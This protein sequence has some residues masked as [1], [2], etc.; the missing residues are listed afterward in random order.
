[1]RVAMLR[2]AR[3]ASFGLQ[4]LRGQVNRSLPV[5]AS[6]FSTSAPLCDSGDSQPKVYE[7]RTYHI[8]PP[9]FW[10]FMEI[11]EEKIHLRMQLSKLVGFW[12][13]DFA[14]RTEVGKARSAHTGWMSTLNKLLP[15][16]ESQD[17]VLLLPLPWSQLKYPETTGGCYELRSYWMTPGSHLQEPFRRTIQA[18][19]AFRYA[20]LLGVWS[21]EFG[22]LNR[23]YMLWH[24]QDLDQ[25]M[26]G[27]ARAAQ[28]PTI[29]AA[30]RE[31]APNLVHQWSKILLPTSFSPM[32]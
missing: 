28:D 24:H 7:L 20:D 25:R 26:L 27:R 22:E 12:R 2:H 3:Q 32:K 21:S 16:V 14:H 29:I 30:S 15:T 23:V 13:Y 6:G 5:S 10:E 9:L 11:L 1:M 17:N 4:F 31:S 19:A 18:R 8:K